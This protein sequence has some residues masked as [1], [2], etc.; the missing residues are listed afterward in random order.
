MNRY[1]EQGMQIVCGE[2]ETMSRVR[3]S[4]R[5][6]GAMYVFFEIDGMPDSR[7]GCLDILDRTQV[8]LAPGTFFGPGSQSFFRIC[9]CRSPTA[10]L[11]AMNRLRPALS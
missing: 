6:K 1:C 4:S 10:L 7:A 2:L 5:P 11:D 8:G 3:L 9:F